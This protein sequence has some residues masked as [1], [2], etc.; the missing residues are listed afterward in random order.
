[1]AQPDD[2][3]DKKAARLAEKLRENLRKRKAQARAQV[4]RLAAPTAGEGESAD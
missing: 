1:M 3:S 2:D 4:P